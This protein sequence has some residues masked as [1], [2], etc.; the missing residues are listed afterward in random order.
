MGAP[1]RDREGGPLYC[2]LDAFAAT[3]RIMYGA[4][5][6]ASPG[7]RPLLNENPHFIGP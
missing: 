1:K 6:G 3:I 5:G 2:N 7:C 4:A